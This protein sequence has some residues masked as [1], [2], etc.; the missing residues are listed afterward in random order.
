MLNFCGDVFRHVRD[1]K[2][3]KVISIC[4]S[5]FF[6]GRMRY[7]ICMRAYINGDG[8]GEG[9]HLYMFFVVMRGEFDPLLSWPFKFIIMLTLI[10]QDNRMQW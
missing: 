3:G 8:F 6:S 10:D 9:I 4:S 5:P 2:A 7:K 1:A